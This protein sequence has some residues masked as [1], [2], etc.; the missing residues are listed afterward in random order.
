MAKVVLRDVAAAAGVSVATVSKVVSERY[1]NARIPPATV[2]R[3][4]AVVEEL[5]YVPNHAARSLRAQRTGQIGLVLNTLYGPDLSAMLTFDGGLLL[6]LSMAAQ[7]FDL[8]AL[9]IYPHPNSKAIAEPARYLDGRIDGLLVRCVMRSEERLLHLVDPARLPLVAIWRQD[10]PPTVGYADVDHYGGARLAVQHLLEL[11]HR[12]IAYHGPDLSADNPHLAIRY[13]GYLDT[14]RDAGISVPPTWHVRSTASLFALLEGAD[15]VT[16]VFA[17]Y[18]Q[19]AAELTAD[20][21]QRGIR[22]PAD[23]SIVSFDDM[24]N[25]GLL[26]GGLTTVHQP[27]QEMAI[28][29]VRN[30]LA[31]IDG[32]PAEQCRSLIPTR[33][34][35]RNSTAAPRAST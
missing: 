20:L 8:P 14:L 25:A 23:L 22:V 27:I 5:G 4:R 31:L 16:A 19:R 1:G 17:A 10:V 24:T 34:I 26:V 35:V 9:V 29:A 7:E 13:H 2:A 12:R 28:E 30:L 6:G 11:G 3:V 32:A 21:A 33:L 18:D 15:A